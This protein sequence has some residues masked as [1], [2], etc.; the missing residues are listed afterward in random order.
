[1]THHKKYANIARFYASPKIQ[2]TEEGKSERRKMSPRHPFRK[3]PKSPFDESGPNST[4][5]RRYLESLENPGR[6]KSSTRTSEEL[7]KP[8]KEEILKESE[9][10]LT[11]TPQEHAPEENP[12][13]P[14]TEP[15]PQ[16]EPAAI[17]AAQP[18][19][20]ETQT[21]TPEPT[22]PETPIPEEETAQ[23]QAA[24][25]EA[26]A[27]EAE[28]NEI[29]I[30]FP[31]SELDLELA[32]LLEEAKIEA[33][34]ARAAQGA[35]RSDILDA[36]RF[37]KDYPDPV[38]P[39]RH[40][41]LCAICHH[42]EREAIEQAFLQWRRPG[43]IRHEFKLSRRDAIY[44]H[45]H[46]LGLF[47]RRAR[48]VRFV[49]E[50]VMEESTLRAP[51]AESMVRAVRAYSCLDERGRWVEPPRRLIISREPYPPPPPLPAVRE[52]AVEP[53]LDPEN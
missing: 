27:A 40:E 45:A 21:A 12:T 29:P 52:I 23:P 24:Q 11:P 35:N 7:R 10:I 3:A 44:R 5:L 38:A 50:K 33:D 16:N 2:N 15:P 46:A 19:T 37:P 22:A 18:E 47:E 36:R 43:D 34:A 6:D 41:R 26:Q 20:P 51:T 39:N 17:E 14:R 13:T 4:A 42:E 48:D 30:D 53:K 1:L 28:A 8:T 9:E 31:S 25:L 32:Q 49:L